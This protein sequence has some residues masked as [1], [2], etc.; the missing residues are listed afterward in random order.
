[1]IF[2]EILSLVWIN[3]LEN[4]AKVL[5][6]SLGIIVGAATIIMVIGIGKGGQQDVADQFKNLN[7]GAIEIS[8]NNSGGANR[9]GAGA[10]G[11][12]GGAGGRM[13]SMPQG[14][15]SAGGMGGM[16]FPP[17][18]M[19]SGMMP[20]GM[21]P[22]LESTM[23]VYFTEDS[24]E[25][26]AL[27]VPDL[28]SITMS[29]SGKYSIL[30][31]DLEEAAS[32]TVAGV[33]SNYK[34]VSN[35]E[36]LIGEFFTDEDNAA[37]NK[38]CVLGNT[39]ALSMFNNELEAYDSIVNIDGRSYTVVGVLK[40]MGSMASGISPDNTAYIPYNT[41]TKYIFGT[42]AAPQITAVAS[43]VTKVPEIKTNIETVLKKIYPG[44]SFTIN[45]AGSKMEAASQSANTLSMLLI[46]VAS[47]VFIVGGIGIM[48]VL[49]VS[50]KERT[51]EIGILKALG[52]SKT[53]ILLE[54]LIEAAVIGVFGGVVGVITGF[55]LMPV[56]GRFMTVIPTTQSAILALTFAVFTATVFG[57]YPALK[58][59]Q[60]IPI[61]ALNQE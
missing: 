7:A 48:N 15:G 9:G 38:V 13:M 3:I 21:M 26:L 5:L 16:P 12:A 36:V 31:G 54:F 45:D 17:A 27:F 24:I 51:R 43:D 10:A 30:G 19:P 18:G 28:S 46:A 57:F 35:L 29:I 52:C 41:S 22:M 37:K 58:A 32:N 2:S 61:E 50:V 6:T 55:A 53:D 40:E 49:F 47:I 39:L 25:E 34:N 20:G 1:M 23:N 42:K 60:L 59:S 8:A 33:L 11:G 14:R 56:L 4:K 44:G